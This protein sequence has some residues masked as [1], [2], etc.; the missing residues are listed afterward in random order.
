MKALAKG[1]KSQKKDVPTAIV[2]IRSTFIENTI[3][4]EKWIEL[5]NL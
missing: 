1:L 4:L 3:T 2:L 5:A